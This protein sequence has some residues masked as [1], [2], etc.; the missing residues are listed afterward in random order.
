MVLNAQNG[1]SFKMTVKEL[2]EKLS[3]C[4][5]NSTVYVEANRVPNA[6]VVQEYKNP[7][8]TFVY[9]ADE[10]DYIDTVLVDAIKI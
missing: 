9:I 8:E 1:V 5:P 4:N 3:K 2:M 10:L 6:T 7:N